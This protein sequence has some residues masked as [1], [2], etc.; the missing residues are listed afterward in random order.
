M[1]I[2]IRNADTSDLDDLV[3]LFDKYMNFYGQVSEIGR[4]KR[5]LEARMINSEASIF[6]AYDE[7]GQGVGF[8]LNYITFS[9]VSLAKIIILNDLYVDSRYRKLG[10]G[11][12][13]VEKSLSLAKQIGAAEVRLSTATDNQTAQSLYDKLGFKRNSEFFAYAYS[14]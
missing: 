8:V 9:S 14:I 12:M 1:T 11:G 10:V 4:F 5:Y 3:N 2:N 6:L 7:H 13:L